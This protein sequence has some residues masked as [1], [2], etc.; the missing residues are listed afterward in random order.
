[1]IQLLSSMLLF[2]G[3]VLHPAIATAHSWYPGRCCKDRDCFA[4]DRV[5][6]LTDGTLLLARGSIAVR[7]TKSFPIEASSRRKTAL[8]RLG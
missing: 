4:A 1:M 7:V 2:G 8:L 3:A 6:R 5:E